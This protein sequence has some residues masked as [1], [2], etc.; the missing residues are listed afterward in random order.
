MHKCRKGCGRWCQCDDPENELGAEETL[1]PVDCAHE[2]DKDGLVIFDE[3]DDEVGLYPDE[4]TAEI[5]L[6]DDDDRDPWR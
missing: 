6:D 4:L 5:D 2:C 1:A 3:E